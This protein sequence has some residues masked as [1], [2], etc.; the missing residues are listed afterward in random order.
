MNKTPLILAVMIAVLL[1]G[2]LAG[3][4]PRLTIPEAEFDFGYSP[5]NSAVS[6][7]FWLHSTGDDSL[8]IVKVTPGCGCTQAPLQKDNLG[9]GDSTQLE[10]IFSTG[11]YSSRVTKTPRIQ[12]NEGPPD[13]LVRI[14]TD[15]VVNPDSTYPVIM[16]PYK[17]DLTQ[18]GEKVRDEI[19]FTIKNV[20]PEAL[21]PS[22]V[23]AP[24]DYLDIQLPKSIP[25]GKSAEGVV[26]VKK[27]FLDKAFVKSFTLQMNDDKKSRFTIP[28]T[29]S[30]RSQSAPG[31]NIA[32]PT[33]H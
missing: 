18:F 3:A 9:V 22:M 21:T 33:G 26:K 17:L 13:K 23:Y 31:E 30:Q 5:Q 24:T 27:A 19:R 11:M 1:L 2:T 6:H 25:A 28:V 15:V 10:V 4:A 29:R 20:S 8:K 12:T 7:V 14:T 32:V 16:H